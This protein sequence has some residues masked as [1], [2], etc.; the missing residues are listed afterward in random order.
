MVMQTDAQTVVPQMPLPLVTL[1]EAAGMEKTTARAQ[2][3]KRSF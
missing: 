3:F 1:P 2:D